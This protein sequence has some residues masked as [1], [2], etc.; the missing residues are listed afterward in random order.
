[1]GYS[2]TAEQWERRNS[3][4]WTMWQAVLAPLQML[5]MVAS[6]VMILRYLH[7][8][9]GFALANASVIAK[10]IVLT[11]I[12]TTGALWEHDV[13]GKYLFAPQFFWEDVGSS[14][15]CVLHASYPIAALLGAS[16]HTLAV[17]ILFAYLSYCVNAAQYLIKLRRTRRQRSALRAAQRA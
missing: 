1:M 8:G 7:T 5:V 14:I 6:A 10:L 11:L 15:V 4:R 9:S 13:Y 16:E 3:S 12:M 17:V 2:Y